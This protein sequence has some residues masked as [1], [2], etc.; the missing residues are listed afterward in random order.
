MKNLWFI[1]FFRKG[2]TLCGLWRELF[3]STRNSGI[4]DSNPARGIYPS[5]SLF[6]ECKLQPCLS[7]TIANVPSVLLAFFFSSAW[8]SDRPSGPPS[9]KV[10]TGGCFHGDE[11][12][13]CLAIPPRP[14]TS[15]GH[16][17]QLIIMAL[18]SFVGPWPLFQFFDPLHRR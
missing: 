10:G 8:R 3:S 7:N 18:Q 13:G 15:S 9:L 11:A 4:A 1:M 17:A 2:C 12:A 14:Y 5:L 6:N 16:G